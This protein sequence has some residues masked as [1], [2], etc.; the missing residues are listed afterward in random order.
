MEF[1]VDFENVQTQRVLE[2][3]LEGDFRRPIPLAVDLD[4]A[5]QFR[6]QGLG[7]THL[8]GDTLRFRV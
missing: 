7:M 8:S 4:L 2:V 3:A 1:A 5:A 6:V